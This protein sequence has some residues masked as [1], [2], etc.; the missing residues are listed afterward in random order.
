MS[1]G[2][3]PVPRL[4]Q[5]RTR[6]SREFTEG[7]A[8]IIHQTVWCA[9][10]CPVSQR[11]P[12]QQSIAQSAGDTWPELTISWSHRTVRC[13]PDSVW[14]AD[15][16]KGATVGFARIGRRSSTGQALFM[17]GGAPDCLVR[18]PTEGKNCLP[19]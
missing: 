15:K 6:R 1:T 14:C 7:T 16:T 13:A 10:D 12:R 19:N 9:P 4:A 5:R 8:A 18:H 2:Q 3:C 11:R 17:S